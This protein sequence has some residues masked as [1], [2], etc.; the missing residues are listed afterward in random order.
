MGE[1]N[2]SEQVSGV[3]EDLMKMIM[4]TRMLTNGN[5]TLTERQTYRGANDRMKVSGVQKS[6]RK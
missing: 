5:G 2:F 6:P 1:T 4:K 3:Y